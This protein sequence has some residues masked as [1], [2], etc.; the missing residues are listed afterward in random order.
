MLKGTRRTY[1]LRN[2]ARLWDSDIAVRSSNKPPKSMR[3]GPEFSRQKVTI[4]SK[5]NFKLML[6]YLHD[7]KG[8]ISN[9]CFSTELPNN[10]ICASLHATSGFEKF[11]RHCPRLK[12]MIFLK[13]SSKL[14]IRNLCDYRLMATI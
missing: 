14:V 4:I 2:R 3:K 9:E 13:T 10:K 5:I 7:I 6:N 12:E 11:Y 8:I 1:T